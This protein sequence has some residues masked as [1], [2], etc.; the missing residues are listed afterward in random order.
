MSMAPSPE[1]AV[2]ALGPE[3]EPGLR[4]RG[5]RKWYG[6]TRALDSLDIEARPGEIVG[7][8]GP[9][10]AGKSTLIKILAGETSAD[11][12]TIVLDGVEWDPHVHRERVAVVHQEPQLF[13]NLTVADNL[14]VG[15]E[16]TRALRRG[17]D[18][19][20]RGLLADLAILELADVP[21]GYVPLAAQQRTEIARALAREARVFLFDEPNSA[22]TDEESSDL[23]RRIHALAAAGH[24]VILVSHRLAELVEHADRVAIILDGTCTAIIAHEGLTQDAIAA[25]LVVGQ[26]VREPEEQIVVHLGEDRETALRLRDWT[27]DKGEFQ[28][29]EL[30]VRAGEIVAFVGV[31]GSGARELVRSIAGFERGS[32]HIEIRERGRPT[33]M[34]RDTSFVSA[35]RQGSLFA[36]FTVGDNMVSRLSHEISTAVGS[37]RRGRMSEIAQELR[38]QFQV[39]AGSIHIPIRSLSGGNQQKVA[40]SAAIVKRPEVLVLEEPTRGVDIGSKAEIYRLMREYAQTGHAVIIFCT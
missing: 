23:F 26:A 39:K 21:L 3:A 30:H 16:G 18:A 32:G 27:H 12:G 9:N 22:L 36:N 25:E 29:V 10:G 17:L 28:G 37:L 38:E 20:E 40:I 1:V 7:V 33:S 19:G 11:S 4:I 6:D 24:V 2:G 14:M 13:P 31:E 8:A 5:L 34:A 15:R 35:D